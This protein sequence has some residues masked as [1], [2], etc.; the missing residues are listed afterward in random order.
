MAPSLKKTSDFR[1]TAFVPSC[2]KEELKKSKITQKLASI[3]HSFIDT[4]A[5]EWALQLR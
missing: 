3:V 2:P 1:A 5:R 4:D